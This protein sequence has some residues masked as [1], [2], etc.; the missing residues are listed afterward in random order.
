MVGSG[1]ILFSL[2]NTDTSFIYSFDPSQAHGGSGGTL[3]VRW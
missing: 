1:G 3:G 2:F